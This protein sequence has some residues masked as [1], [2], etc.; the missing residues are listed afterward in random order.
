[1]KRLL[2]IPF[3]LSL[4]LSAAAGQVAVTEIKLRTDP[5]GARV[6]PGQSL[7]IQVLA[8]GEVT[9]GDG[10][11]KVRLEDTEAN[12]GIREDNGGWISKP[13]RFQ[14]S[15]SEEFHRSDSGGLWGRILRQ[16]GNQ[17]VIK[18]SVLYTAPERT[19][20][21]TLEATKGSLNASLAIRV[22]QDAPQSSK[23]EEYSFPGEQPSRDPYRALAEHYAPFIAQ[24]TWWQPKSD[25]LARFDLDGDWRGDNNWENA[26]I[27]SSQAYVHYAAMET[28]THWF[29]IYNFFHARDYSDS[30]VGG[31]CH[32]NDNEGMIFTVEK[33]GSPFGKP[34]AM[35][36]LAHNNIYSY[37][38]DRRV[39]NG[40]HNLD[41]EVEFYE[42]SHPAVFIEAGG[43][44]VLGTD[45]GK[46][47][48]S[49]RDQKFREGTG[50]T[51]IYK[52][53][54]ERPKHG[55]DALVGYDLLPMYDYWWVRAQEGDGRGTTFDEYYIYQPFGG[56]PRTPYVEIAGSFLGRTESSNKAKPFWGW[57]DVRTQ[58]R[59]AL[60]TG[61]W[62]LDPAYSFSLNLAYSGRVSLNYR[63]NP[64]L[65]VGRPQ[66]GYPTTA[67]KGPVA[68]PSQPA[69]TATPSTISSLPLIR[70][71]RASGYNV[72][73]KSGQFDIRLHVDHELIVY[74]QGEEIRYELAG[75]QPPRDDGSETTQPIPRATFTKFE[76]EQ[77]DGRGEIQLLEQPSASNAFTATLK[78][79]DTKSGDDRYHAR[80]RWEWSDLTPL[81]PAGQ[82]TQESAMPP[83]LVTPPPPIEP[84][85]L[86]TSE[87]VNAPQPPTGGVLD[88]HLGA[89]RGEAR[90]IEQIQQSTLPAG[91]ELHSSGN[92]PANY[93]NGPE[94]LFEYRGRVDGTAVFRIRGDRVF[95]EAESGQPTEVE[96]FS[97]SQPLPAMKMREVRVE[98]KDGR[99]DVTLLEVPWDGNGYTAVVR[100]SDPRGG[101]DRYH[102]RLTW[103]Q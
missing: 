59:N 70:P 20:N 42:N 90:Q 32:E 97:F 19:G 72:N 23:T 103:T 83:E 54:A 25:M 69:G 16:A 14:G 98:R 102:F 28:E 78:F 5:D 65:G 8:Y 34:L 15:D 18:D 76:M 22:E 11:K 43:H 67:V 96:R 26:D 92:N 45:D 47:V 87:T 64:Y 50:L 40:I 12:L 4:F 71:K 101:D 29:L 55:N 6:R 62:A 38:A 75:G 9:E 58:K 48:F 52:G 66:P 10:K 57:H 31:T 46:S 89:L 94:G 81:K 49:F 88:Q 79:S 41:G 99:G 2:E 80:L 13:F 44:G 61:Q 95:A 33:D 63:F 35:E 51:Y 85:L 7:V 68:P 3:I 84:P 1:M 86:P 24:E 56:R 21:F 37:G 60:A 73:A 82:L 27:G 74:V 53:R 30:C 93:D 77:R 91:V 100:V 39:R 17:F 36:T